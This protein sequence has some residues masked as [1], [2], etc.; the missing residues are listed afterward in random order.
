MSL[1]NLKAELKRV[2]V[3]QCNV[4]DSMGMS[5]N[6]LNLKINEKI[7]MTV[8]EAKFIRD[9]W[10]PDCTLD[11]LLQSDGDTP[12][13][14]ESL[15]AQADAIGDAMRQA[16]GDDPEVAEIEGLFHEAV[17]EWER[18]EMTKDEVA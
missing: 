1:N 15:H 14:A 13:K 10:L 3:T 6:N 17:N 16:C 2:G 18:N 4:A 8:D 5:N 9:T 12:T 7:P 11:V